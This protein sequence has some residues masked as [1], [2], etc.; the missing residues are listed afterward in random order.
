MIE[1]LSIKMKSKSNKN[2]NKNGNK[3]KKLLS[4]SKL[5]MIYRLKK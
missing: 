4:R 1:Q 5:Q 3:I 2:R